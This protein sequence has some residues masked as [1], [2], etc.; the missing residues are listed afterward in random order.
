MS[1]NKYFTMGLCIFLS[2]FMLMSIQVNA[3]L[4]KSGITEFISNIECSPI[5]PTTEYIIENHNGKKTFMN[6]TTLTSK[7]S[8]QYLLQ[9]EYAVTNVDGF[10]QIFGRYCVAVGTGINVSVGQYIDAQL[11]NGYIIECIVAD[12]KD[13]KHTDDV[14]I[15]TLTSGCCLEFIV[16]TNHLPMD[17]IKMGDCSAYCVEF[18]SP[19][20]KFIIYDKINILK[21]KEDD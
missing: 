19:V 6:Y 3:Y 13:D 20:E 12:I 18:N 15:F 10:R 1:I 21:E 5:E 16:D 4:P 2:T 14:N 9:K 11:E 8:L 7:T 17:I